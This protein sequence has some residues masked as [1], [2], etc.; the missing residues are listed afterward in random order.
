MTTDYSFAT[1]M[2]NAAQNFEDNFKEEFGMTLE[3]ARKDPEFVSKFDK[4]LNAL[5]WELGTAP[6]PF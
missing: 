1:Q 4:S 3:E 2:K 5:M 6:S